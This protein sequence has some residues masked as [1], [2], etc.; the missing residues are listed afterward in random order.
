MANRL[1]THRQHLGLHASLALSLALLLIFV[2]VLAG[3]ALAQDY[4][5]AVPRLQMQVFIEADGT[6]RL[7][8]D[9]TFENQPSGRAID[10][11][12]IGLPTAG[13]NISNMRAAIDGVELFDIRP[14]EYVKPGV[15][16]HLAGRWIS[17]GDTGTLHFEATVP[18][19]L[20]QDVTNRDY[21]SFQITPTWFDDQFIS[22]LTDVQIAIHLPEGVSPE[23]MLYQNEAFGQRALFEDRAVALW[24]FPGERLTGPNLVGVSFPAA[25]IANVQRMTALDLAERWFVAQ[26]TLRWVLGILAAGIFSFIFL[27]FTGGTG[28]TLWV[29]GLAGLTVLF[30]RW[31]LSQWAIFLLLLPGIYFVQRAHKRRRAKAG[32]LPPI[33]QVEGG[34]IKRGLTAPEAAAL[35]EMPLSKV[36]TLIIFG[37]LKKGVLRQISE[38]PFQVAIVQ[39]FQTEAAKE[40]Q[41]ARRKLRKRAAQQAGIV[42][43]GYEHPFLDAI[44]AQPGT[45][46]AKIDFGEA[47]DGFLVILAKRVK[48]FDLSDTQEYYQSIVRR[49]VEQAKTI[50]DIATREQSLDRDME[51]ILLDKDFPT[52]FNTP[53]YSYRPI[54][55]RA[56]SGG[57]SSGGLPS[58]SSGGSPGGAVPSF[59]NVA[60]GFAGW[61]ENTMGSLATAISPGSL[62]SLASKSGFVNLSGID[63]VTGDVFQALASSSRSSGGG[64]GGG[65]SCACAGCACACACAGG[66][67]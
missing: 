52:V 1:P 43:H 21:A 49:A 54:W 42:L 51:W 55:T 7:V 30:I 66:G 24:D 39:E 59:S 3:P 28:L 36:L 45:S 53:A 60:A 8:Y 16:V 38:E 58:L 44:E 22:S 26:T 56:S 50:P 18:D 37:L 65:S 46:L 62:P 63:K 23:D 61:T 10:I 13:Y 9:I 19:L 47:M 15:E 64:G 12:D 6:A 17:P 34:G 11:V 20:F 35:L 67:R 4:L 25:G 48:G 33:A 32:Y 41:E 2:A 27:R 40:N 31:P 29:I 5:F 57:G 14:S